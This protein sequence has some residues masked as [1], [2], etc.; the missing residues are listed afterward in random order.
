MKGSGI[1]LCYIAAMTLGLC[2][3]P[4]IWI[5]I[6]ARRIARATAQHSRKT[7]SFLS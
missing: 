6:V 2:A 5:L 4:I 7:W 3:V 1:A